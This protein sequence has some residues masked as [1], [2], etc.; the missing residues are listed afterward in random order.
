MIQ[1]LNLAGNVKGNQTTYQLQINSTY[2]S[3]ANPT[4]STAFALNG[5]AYQ[6]VTSSFKTLY[7]GPITNSATILGKIYSTSS[8]IFAEINNVL[9]P[10][11]YAWG[12]L[13]VATQ[14]GVTTQMTATVASSASLQVNLDD[15][16][17]KIGAFFNVSHI[18]CRMEQCTHNWCCF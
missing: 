16:M 14:S 17:S 18:L 6:D 12:N 1:S 7:Y 8:I 15:F 13:S 5:T 9:D 11:I 4:Y 3:Y 10:M 2:S